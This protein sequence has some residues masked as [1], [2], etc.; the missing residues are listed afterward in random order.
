[1][2]KGLHIIGVSFTG[3]VNLSAHNNDYKKSKIIN[4]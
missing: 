1:M 3:G 2:S 4:S